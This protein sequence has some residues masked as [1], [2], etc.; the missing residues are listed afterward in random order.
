VSQVLTS[1]FLLSMALKVHAG[2][3][4]GHYFN[5]YERYPHDTNGND[6]EATK[7]AF[8]ARSIGDISLP[9]TDR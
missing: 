6:V 7:S 8:S 4:R 2:F 9:G 5:I 3:H 1:S